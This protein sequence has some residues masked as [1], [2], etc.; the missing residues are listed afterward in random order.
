MAATTSDD[1]LSVIDQ[2]PLNGRYWAVFALLSAVGVVDFFDFFSVGFL[3]AVIG[4]QW[5]LTYGA[6]AAILLGGGI[7]A[8]VGS[9]AGG[10]L[11]TCGAARRWS[12]AAPS[13]ARSERRRSR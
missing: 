9:L 5:H 4:P 6:A 8:I 11:V 12:S 7:G 1:L 13:S 3:V 10:R 2:C